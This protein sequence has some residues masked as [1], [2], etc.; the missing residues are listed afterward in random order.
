MTDSRW[1]DVVRPTL[2]D[3]VK[4]LRP[5]DLVAGLFSSRLLTKDDVEKLD[6][7]Q[8]E[9]KASTTLLIII[10]PGKGPKAYDHFMEV[11]RKTEGQEFVADRLEKVEEGMPRPR[12]KWKL[13]ASFIP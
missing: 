3:L 4:V 9:E 6:R 7:C 12:G 8:S 1:E 11:L 5:S 10:L 13:S 2:P